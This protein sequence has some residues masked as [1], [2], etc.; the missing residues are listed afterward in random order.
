MPLNISIASAF[1]GN[2][3]ESEVIMADESG[4]EKLKLILCQNIP[5]YYQPT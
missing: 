2:R 1:P 5:L 4:T 3:D